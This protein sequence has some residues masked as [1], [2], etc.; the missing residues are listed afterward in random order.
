MSNISPPH[1]KIWLPLINLS[2]LINSKHLFNAS[3]LLVWLK[4]LGLSTSSI[5]DE[6]EKALDDLSAE[7]DYLVAK[8]VYDKNTTKNELY[9]ILLN[10]KFMKDKD[11]AD[12]SLQF[13]E[14]WTLYVP[15]YKF[16]RELINNYVDNHSADELIYLYYPCTTRI[17]NR[18]D[19][20]GGCD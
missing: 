12:R 19:E 16:G 11:D 18:I 20:N 4:I 2:L 7:V 10:Y 13:I 17:L 6:I 14:N 5:D 15:I 3:F 8:L 1:I 9:D